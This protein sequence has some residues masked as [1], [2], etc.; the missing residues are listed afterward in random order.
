MGDES[1]KLVKG[2]GTD[3]L[4]GKPDWLVPSSLLD[5]RLRFLVG[6][7]GGV[8]RGIRLGALTVWFI[9]LSNWVF[10]SMPLSPPASGIKKTN[11]YFCALM[12]FGEI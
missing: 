3:L 9:D 11:C 6:L 8:L 12:K 5:L 1:V 7:S 2:F 10:S 4:L